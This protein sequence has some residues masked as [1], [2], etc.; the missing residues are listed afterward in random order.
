ML[1]FFEIKENNRMIF[2][3]YTF[4][5]AKNFVTPNNSN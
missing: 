5:A 3:I 4:D 1:Y 2:T